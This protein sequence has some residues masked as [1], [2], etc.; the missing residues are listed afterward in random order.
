M[1]VIDTGGFVLLSEYNVCGSLLLTSNEHILRTVGFRLLYFFKFQK[2]CL[3]VYCSALVRDATKKSDICELYT[4][5][6]HHRNLSVIRLL[7]NIYQHGREIRTMSLNTQYL[8]LF[9]NPRDQLQVMT[10]SRQ[11]FPH[12]SYQFMGKFNQATAKPY[13]YLVIYKTPRLPETQNR[14]TPHFVSDLCSDN[15]KSD[16][17]SNCDH[18][19]IVFISDLHLNQHKEQGCRKKNEV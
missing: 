3:N 19:G 1:C 17:L 16:D 13:G 18:C 14:C 15:I 11:I 5:G 4:E 7:Q 6:S 10:L 9:K 8:V 12:R 2:R